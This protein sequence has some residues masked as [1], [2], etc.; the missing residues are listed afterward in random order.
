MVA[1]KGPEL[2]CYSNFQKGSSTATQ[3]RVTGGNLAPLRACQGFRVFGLSF[4]GVA[5]RCFFRGADLEVS[6]KKVVPF[7]G[8]YDQGDSLLGPVYAFNFSEKWLL[9]CCPSS[10]Q[11]PN[12]RPR[13]FPTI[14]QRAPLNGWRG[15][16]GVWTSQE[17]T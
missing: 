3:C 13:L 14:Q 11:A 15:Y 6:I 2:S 4:P 16:V 8:R 10:T 12:K 9:G 7:E 5:R 17:P 1:V